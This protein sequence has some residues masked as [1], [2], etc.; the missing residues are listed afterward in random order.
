MYAGTFNVSNQTTDDRNLFYWLFKNQ[1]VQNP[2][3]VVWIDGGPGWSAMKGLFEG[4]GPLRLDRNGT[5][6]DDYIISLNPQGSWLD[7]ADVLY[8]D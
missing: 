7:Q 4:N 5:G 3:L 2:N 6:L 8:L 1:E